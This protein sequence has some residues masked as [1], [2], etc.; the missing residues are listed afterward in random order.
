MYFVFIPEGYEDRDIPIFNGGVKHLAP[1]PKAKNK[2]Q[3]H[4]GESEKANYSYPGQNIT[5]QS[6]IEF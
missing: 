3:E 4:Y 6:S 2:Y 5:W 1:L